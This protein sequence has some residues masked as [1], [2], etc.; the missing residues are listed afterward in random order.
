M[1]KNIVFGL[2]STVAAGSVQADFVSFTQIVNAT[3]PELGTG[4]VSPM[5]VVTPAGNPFIRDLNVSLNIGPTVTGGAVWNGDLYA[6]LMH[7]DISGSVMSVLLNRVGRSAANPDGYGPNGFDVI[8]DDQAGQ[9]IHWVPSS[10]NLLTGTYQPDGRLLDPDNDPSLFETAARPAM[11]NG[12]N[13][14]NAGGDWFLYL[15]DASGGFV[16]QLNSWRLDLDVVPE[17]AVGGMLT[18]AGLLA[19]IGWGAVRGGRRLLKRRS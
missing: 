12:F 11:L 7:T 8:L 18:Y 14:M 1:N 2:L 3:V 13:G 6:Q 9:D 19:G 16:S 10:G 4:L 5:N 15:Y 17:P